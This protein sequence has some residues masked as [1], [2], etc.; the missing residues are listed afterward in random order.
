MIRLISITAEN[1]MSYSKL[2][3]NLSE[4]GIVGIGGKNVDDNLADNN[5]AGKSAIFE[6]IVWCLFGQTIRGMSGDEVVN[7][8][9]DKDCSTRLDLMVEDKHYRIIRCRKHSKAGNSV[10]VYMFPDNYADGA[11]LTDLSRAT[12]TDTQ[13]VINNLID[14]DFNSFCRTVVFSGGEVSQFSQATD[15]E[16]KWLFEKLLDLDIYSRCQEIAKERYKVAERQVEL[17][18]IKITQHQDSIKRYQSLIETYGYQILKC[19]EDHS[20]LGL[21]YMK[22]DVVADNV[23]DLKKKQKELFDDVKDYRSRV[24]KLRSDMNEEIQNEYVKVIAGLDTKATMTSSRAKKMKGLV[25]T[26]PT[27]EQQINEKTRDKLVDQLMDEY[28]KIIKRITELE[29][30]MKSKRK[31]YDKELVDL[32][33]GIKIYEDEFERTSQR[34]T[35]VESVERHNHDIDARRMSIQSNIEIHKRNIAEL[36][37]KIKETEELA[38]DSGG[39][40]SEFNDHMKVYKFWID[41]FGLKGIRN[42]ILGDVFPFINKRL[43]YYTN[44]LFGHTIALTNQS[45]LK[46]GNVS[47]KIDL[48]IGDSSYKSASMGERRRIDA[49]ILFALQDLVMQRKNKINV[50][51]IDEI[52]DVLDELGIENVIK[53]LAKKLEISGLESIFVISHNNYIVEAMPKMMVAI[54]SNGMSSIEKEVI[55]TSERVKVAVSS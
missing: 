12:A 11:V 48:M 37:S 25:A 4:Q 1:F 22:E 54:K 20:A 2:E 8:I 13:E 28:N 52:F 10:L 19:D 55:D 42:M 7:R 34:I 27:C 24:A 45:M 21:Q 39:I 47:D 18:K 40:V 53:L 14:I 9:S 17:E 6:S 33:A 36:E 38:I 46:S 35:E 15:S 50:L 32:E 29:I 31:A 51:F 26:C 30:E 5:G 23:D 3:V 49:C 16:R 44:E 41:A 43:E